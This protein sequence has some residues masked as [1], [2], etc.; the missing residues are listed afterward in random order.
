MTDIERHSRLP[1]NFHRTFKP[2]RQYINAM[3]RFAASGQEG[4]YQKISASTGIPMGLSSGKV[5]AILDYCRGM[6]LIS[7]TD[8]IKSSVKRPRLTPFGGIVFLEDPYLKLEIT[9]WIAHLNLCSPLAGADVWYQTFFL[10]ATSLGMQFDRKRFEIY[11]SL[12]F[13]VNGKRI[14]GPIIGMYQDEASFKT[15]SAL[16]ESSGIIQ[17]NVAP[18]SETMACGYGAWT[19]QL[20]RTHFPE[21][22]QIAINNLNEIAGWAVIPAWSKH[23]QRSS[24]EMMERRGL[25]DV[26]RQMEPWIISPVCDVAHAWNRIYEALL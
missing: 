18:L 3:L 5:P 20:I 22:R 8:P 21:R 4:D 1:R 12:A 16:V 11:L 2:E 6:G 7:L 17:R 15:C 26:D 25:I 9:Q 23:N 13:G 10:G 14:I 19:L 24:L